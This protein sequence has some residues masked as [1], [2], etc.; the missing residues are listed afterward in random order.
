ML[1]KWM[2]KRKSRAK[3]KHSQQNQRE[4]ILLFDLKGADLT[5]LKLMPKFALALVF[6]CRTIDII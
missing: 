6:A 5:L 1:T 3:D 2:G 4:C